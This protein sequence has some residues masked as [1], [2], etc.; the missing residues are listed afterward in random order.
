MPKLLSPTLQSNTGFHLA[1]NGAPA[2]PASHFTDSSVK[3]LMRKTEDLLSAKGG[4]K[5]ETMTREL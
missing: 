4:P 5:N 3:M 1:Q 2:K